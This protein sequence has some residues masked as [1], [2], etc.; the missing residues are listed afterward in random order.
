MKKIERAKLISTVMDHRA[1]AIQ[2]EQAWKDRFYEW[3]AM[4]FM[5]YLSQQLATRKSNAQDRN[6]GLRSTQYIGYAHAQIETS[7][8]KCLNSLFSKQPPFEVDPEG[9]FSFEDANLIKSLHAHSFRQD[10]MF[11]KTRQALRFFFIYGVVP[12]KHLWDERWVHEGERVAHPAGIDDEGH[13]TWEYE[14]VRQS[15]LAY[16]GPTSLV[17]D[18]YSFHVEPMAESVESA[19]WVQEEFVRSGD[20]L[21]EQMHLGIYNKVDLKKIGT[22]TI[23]AGQ[24]DHRQRRKE[25][26][27]N[28]DLRSSDSSPDDLVSGMYEV[29]EEWQDDRR[30]T[31]VGNSGGEQA[32]LCDRPNPFY[33]GRKPYTL[34]QYLDIAGEIWSMPMARQLEGVQ[35]EINMIRRMRSDALLQGLRNMWRASRA[36]RNVLREA[37]LAYRPDGVVYA[38][39][40]ELEPLAKPE[41][42][43]FSYKEEEILR[44]DGDIITGITDVVRGGAAASTTA[45]VGT[46]NAN[47]AT[48]RLSLTLDNVADGF[49]EMLTMRHQLYRQ[50]ATQSQVVK[51][52][53]PQGL[54][55]V[56]VP[57]DRVRGN[58]GFRFIAGRGMGQREV[59]RTQLLNLLT[60]SAQNPI[61]GVRMDFDKLIHDTIATFDA[62][63]DP[64]RYLLAQAYES[65]PQEQ[66]LMVM[67]TGVPMP[68]N[69]NDNHVEHLKV[70]AEF[71]Q[72]DQYEQLDEQVRQIVDTHGKQHI[73][74]A[75]NMLALQVGTGASG[76][77]NRAQISGNLNTEADVMKTVNRQNAPSL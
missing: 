13:L 58:Y 61:V 62:L 22:H 19:R 73:P 39:K 28:N 7:V 2:A 64:S 71:T 14:T 30:I 76:S 26:I 67:M 20:Y 43:I 68:V 63:P 1:A 41:I 59:Q 60:I 42:Q 49:D 21:E 4:F 25:V 16:E 37:D 69:P 38:D 33:H 23:P 15:K 55:I 45:T 77:P 57:I 46:L 44:Q 8:A 65:I 70:L 11:K 52:V 51:S 24:T 32:I 47:F 3:E 31:L 5:R 17:V 35:S 18:P 56:T 48:D 74:F 9:G 12:F 53:G 27:G 66:E 72:S 40:D 34:W 75:Q 36:S 29:I 6:K 50:F 10:R 54:K